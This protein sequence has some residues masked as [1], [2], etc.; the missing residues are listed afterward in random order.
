MISKKNQVSYDLRSNALA[1]AGRLDPKSDSF[2][3][4]SRELRI[5]GRAVKRPGSNE[6][7]TAS[8]IYRGVK[9]PMRRKF[10]EENKKCAA[11]CIDIAL[12]LAPNSRYS[13]FLRDYQ[14]KSGKADWTGML[15]PPVIKAASPAAKP[16]ANSKKHHENVSGL[17]K[18]GKATKFPASQR[19]VHGI[20]TNRYPNGAW[21]KEAGI[22]KATAL[23]SP[24]I[25]GVKLIINHKIGNRLVGS[26]GVISRLINARHSRQ[27]RIPN[28][29]KVNITLGG[30]DGVIEGASATM[31]M[32]V[33]VDSLFTG[34]ELD[35]SFA[36]AGDV[37]PDGT[38]SAV[39]G[40]ADNIGC[41]L[42]GDYKLI[43]IPDGNIRQVTDAYIL[44]GFEKFIGCQIFSFKFL[45]EAIALTSKEKPEH[46]QKSI[47]DFNKAAKVLKGKGISALKSDEV[48]LLLKEVLT[49]T[50][51]H[52]SARVLLN[53][54]NGESDKYLSLGVS[55]RQIHHRVGKV[56]VIFAKPLAMKDLSV[57]TT[58]R[59]WL[60]K[61]SDE[62]ERVKTRLSPEIKGYSESTRQVFALL[63]KGR[64]DG[65]NGQGYHKR[66]K[67]A[68]DK[69]KGE[70]MKLLKNPDISKALTN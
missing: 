31:A 61:Q 34:G 9:V 50:P 3:E 45:D 67:A 8:K 13:D 37:N 65:E 16:A 44:N 53:L 57:S 42:E 66:F 22:F 7:E 5:T 63:A 49:R 36:V 32:A 51:N 12:R 54:A 41:G 14:K 33:A 43:G 52:Q 35:D 17:I 28:G 4:I 21:V 47:D 24:G 58:D 56:Q 6:E 23:R 64:L 38:V 68:W 55:F 40:I 26:A 1:I 2:R 29:F 60:K 20:F 46:I 70:R 69:A 19:G 25:D 27:G 59:K 48:I 15:L 30:K 18:G 62:L 11:Y 10:N 39:G